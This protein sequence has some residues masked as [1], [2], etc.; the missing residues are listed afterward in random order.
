MA[1][2]PVSVRIAGT[3]RS[4][5]EKI[6]TNADLEKIVDTSDEWI[7]ARSG[8][9]RRHIAEPGTPLSELATDAGRKA[10]A[11]A[12]VE[13]EELDLILVG[14]VTGDFKFPST[15]TF[16]QAKLGARN[17]AS[18]DISAACS[19][20]I[21][22]LHVVKSI[23]KAGE[24]NKVLLVGGE[25]L[26]SMTDW[27]DRSTCVLFGDAAGAAVLRREEGGTGGVLST[28]IASN[29]ELTHLLYG[30]GGGSAHPATDRTLSP[31]MFT[32]KMAGR[33]VFKH[34][35][36]CM[37]EAAQE[38]LRRAN[39]QPEDIDVFIPHQANIRII[40][41]IAKRFKFPSEKIY[42]NIQE[43]GNTSAASIP[44]AI[45]EAREKGIVRPGH[46]VLCSAFGGGFTWASTVIEF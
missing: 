36:V 28:Y 2:T 19:G 26:T 8:I 46:K 30:P 38:A 5:P 24:A 14:T 40:E 41:A 27:T 3:G 43:Y 11:E 25:I 35:V 18:L 33:E 7:T 6:L 16:I 12:N 32:V 21:Y 34:A 44:L 22:G 29:G 17:A 42:I 23:I 9:K 37:E 31:D 4:V 45:D 13:P 39:L 15:A 20:W 1:E 10:L